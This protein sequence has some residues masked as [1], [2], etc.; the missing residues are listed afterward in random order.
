M[1]RPLRLMAVLAHPD[2]ESMGFG[3]TLARYAA[4]GVET[5]LV[6]ATRGQ[7]GWKLGAYPGPEVVASWRTRELEQAAEILGIRHLTIL[8]YRDGEL[9][10]VPAMA[11]ITRIAATVRLHRPDVVLTFGP[12]G[13]YGHPDHIAISQLTG[14]AIV[15]A[16]GGHEPLAGL[17]PHQVSKLYH[18]APTRTLMRGYQNV[19]GELGSRVDGVERSF[20]GFDR[21]LPAARIA[22]D[23][24]VPAT[25]DAILRHRSQLRYPERLLAMPLSAW[26]ELFA[27]QTFVR[28]FSLLGV[29]RELERDL[30]D[31]LR[32]EAPRLAAV[33]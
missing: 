28:A 26:R 11:A 31:G 23:P 9:D 3:P 18:L 30:F 19:F 32:A 29:G 22:T 21:W 24:F 12:E 17:D 25:R 10:R 33:A 13:V 16:A 15:K 20:E 7:K 5:S 1:S 4:E 14:A 2:D 8:G 27:D 6:M